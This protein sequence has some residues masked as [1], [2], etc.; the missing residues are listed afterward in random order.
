MSIIVSALHRTM[1][2]LHVMMCRQSNYYELNS[3]LRLHLPIAEAEKVH[4]LEELEFTGVWSLCPDNA[5]GG[6]A[7]CT[8][9]AD[10][11]ERCK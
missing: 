8:V 4:T 3:F 1:E 5:I 7:S 2:M 6:W 11:L 10:T 9:H